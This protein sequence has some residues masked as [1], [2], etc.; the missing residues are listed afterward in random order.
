MTG[1]FVRVR[2]ASSTPLAGLGLD[3]LSNNLLSSSNIYLVQSGLGG[4]HG[5]WTQDQ[6]CKYRPSQLLGYRCTEGLLAVTAASLKFLRALC[7]LQFGSELLQNHHYIFCPGFN[8]CPV[9][10][11]CMQGVQGVCLRGVLG[12]HHR[13]LRVLVKAMVD[14]IS[15]AQF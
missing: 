5:Q 7:S 1:R 15:R 11:H 4:R 12:I 13:L 10:F 6:D 9:A 2:A 3:R 8:T 14:T